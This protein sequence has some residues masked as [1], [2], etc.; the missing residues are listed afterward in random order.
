[1]QTTGFFSTKLGRAALVSILA[2]V[3]M[4]CVALSQQI[5]ASSIVVASNAMVAGELA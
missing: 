1:M 3:A 4:N 5:G 2:M